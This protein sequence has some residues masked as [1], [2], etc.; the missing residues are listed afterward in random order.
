MRPEPEQINFIKE[1]FQNMKSK[2]DLLD[3]LNYSKK[4]LFGE[5]T[6]PFQLKVLTY[7]SNPKIALKRY[8]SFTIKKKSG[9]DRKIHAP[10]KGLK[11]IQRSL[12]LILQIVFTP[13]PAATGFISGK[14]IVDNASFHARSNY[15]YNLDLKDFFPSID[16]A[17]VW[18]CLQLKP[19]NL[20]MEKNRLEL[21]NIIAALC[22]STMEVERPDKNGELE[23]VTKNVL[24]QGAPTSPVISNVVCQRLD[25]LLSAVARR[26]G[27]RYSRYADDITF[28]SMHNVYQK[29]SDFIKELNRIIDQQGF[30]IN[31]AKTRL[32]K[33]GYRQEVT[34][35]IINEKGN[36]RSR[37]V[38]QLRSW[39]Y[40]WETYGFERA[41]T[42]FL[43]DYIGD[44]GHVMK[45]K[46][47]MLNVLA[48]KIEY[49]RMV[50]GINNPLVISLTKRYNKLTGRKIFKKDSITYTEE[51]K[52]LIEKMTNIPDIT[53]LQLLKSD[54][55]KEENAI[56]D[57]KYIVKLLNLFTQ[58]N[59]LKYTTHLWEKKDGKYPWGD[60]DSFIK[61]YLDVISS[62]DNSFREL[63]NFNKDIYWNVISP[64]LIQN[65]LH[66]KD[67]KPIP[68][69]WGRHN[70]KIGYRYPDLLKNWMQK[71]PGKSPFEM[72]VPKEF[73]PLEPIEGKTLFYFEDFVD[74]FKKCIEFRRNDF[75]YKIKQI[76]KSMSFDFNITIEGLNG[77]TFYTDTFQIETA[78]ERIFSQIRKI[79]EHPSVIITGNYISD[80][81]LIQIEILHKGSFC[82]KPINDEKINLKNNKGDFIFIRNKLHSL[83]DWSVESRFRINNDYKFFRFDYLGKKP[84][85]EPI[86]INT[87]QG[88]KH[89][90]TFYV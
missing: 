78:L 84:F 18:K 4:I 5:E 77:L 41:Y 67:N 76:T 31:L 62:P 25:F 55:T 71:N 20:S 47:N 23:T 88:F 63:T 27:L 65:K 2:E 26:F 34:G 80:L 49:L 28:S 22:C 21:A 69:R 39:L 56:H 14:S 10:V 58:E 81:G 42:I 66:E 53:G 3:L 7:Y 85:I 16:Q 38:K 24:P 15:V 29:E 79:P 13:H 73:L 52:A 54:V 50:K 8:T 74:V 36:V 1:S 11:A 9:S 60:Y 86:E 12:N 30:Q 59:P 72:E 6:V 64:F 44:K 75:L 17:R 57:P 37:Y 82:D 90:L 48:G 51:H 35:L 61:D 45:G 46:P 33:E 70:L 40:Y 83:C 89:I 43:N 87:A 68:Y 32:Q 19:F